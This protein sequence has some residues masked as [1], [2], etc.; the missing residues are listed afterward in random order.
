MMQA[1]TLETS[2]CSSSD[3]LALAR[4]PSEHVAL[5]APLVTPLLARALRRTQGRTSVESVL[6]GALENRYQLWV[7]ASTVGDLLAALVTEVVEYGDGSKTCVIGLLGGVA[8]GRWMH[9][10]SELE[11]WAREAGCTRL[12]VHG[13]RGWARMLKDYQ[14]PFVVL[15]KEL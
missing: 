1:Q 15:R 13:R 14:Q 2:P 9:L 4:V 7:I 8:M 11:Q 3:E 10:M 6:E 5:V 12:E